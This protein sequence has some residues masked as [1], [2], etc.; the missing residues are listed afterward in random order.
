MSP[1]VRAEADSVSGSSGRKRSS[2][3][4]GAENKEVASPH[5]TVN[6]PPSNPSPVFT[7]GFVLRVHVLHADACA[8]QD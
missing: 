6:A 8:H 1:K 3:E 2:R 7:W 5:A 4:W